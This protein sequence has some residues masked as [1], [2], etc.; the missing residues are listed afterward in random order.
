MLNFVMIALGLG[1]FSG[2]P[3]PDLVSLDIG[4]VQVG[5]EYGKERNDSILRPFETGH[6]VSLEVE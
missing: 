1:F 2:F 3:K 4:S 6:E 5:V